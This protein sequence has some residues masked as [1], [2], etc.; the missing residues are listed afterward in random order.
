MQ[1]VDVVIVRTSFPMKVMV[2]AR[3]VAG[4]LASRK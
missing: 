2:R 1:V 4:P 3:S